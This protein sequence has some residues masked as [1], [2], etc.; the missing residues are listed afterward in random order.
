[1]GRGQPVI[2]EQ[3][4]NSTI[5]GIKEL[6]SVDI[7]LS[8]EKG[9]TISGSFSANVEFL[10]KLVDFLESGKTISKEFDICFVK[11]KY[12][13]EDR[14]FVVSVKGSDADIVQIA[15]MATFQFKQLFE[16][17]DSKTLINDFINNLLLNNIFPTN[18]ESEARAVGIDPSIKRGVLLAEAVGG[19][20][21]TVYEYLKTKDIE[22]DSGKYYVVSIEH[23]FI[24]VVIEVNDKKI[25]EKKAK[26]LLGAINADMPLVV[27]VGYGLVAEDISKLK[28]SYEQARIALDVTKMFNQEKDVASYTKLG[29]GRIVYALSDDMCDMFLSE[30]FERKTIDNIDEE[31]L[32]TVNTFFENSLNISETSRQL[33]IHRNTLI[34][35]LNKLQRLTGLD[36][37]NL[38]D[39]ITFK[40]SVMVNKKIRTS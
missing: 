18:V 5:N 7:C 15:K 22:I 21:T 31:T 38:D 37:R 3:V 25:L 35:R 1:M 26:E 29:L 2:S 32:N 19:K 9:A 17:Y 33:F 12:P 20:S 39:A 23:G 11:E 28:L 34:Y 16:A 10:N 30:H 27:R 4:L 6:T 40:L 8:D 36:V 24:A 14:S 13:G